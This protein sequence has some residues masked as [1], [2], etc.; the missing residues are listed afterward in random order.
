MEV[1]ED[2]TTKLAQVFFQFL[3]I[4]TGYDAINVL[5]KALTEKKEQ[6]F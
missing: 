5:K 6:T 2:K 3:E 4:K 1:S